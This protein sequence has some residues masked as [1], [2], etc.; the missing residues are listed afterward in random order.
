MK[1]SLFVWS[2]STRKIS[3]F[4]VGDFNVNLLK[5]DPN[6]VMDDFLNTFYSSYFFPLI[7][8]PTRVGDHSVSL[9]DNIF[10]NFLGK[11]MNSGILLSDLSDHFPIFQCSLLQA[12]GINYTKKPKYKR[13]MTKSNTSKFENMLANMSWD[14]IYETNNADLAYKKFMNIVNTSFNHCFPLGSSFKKN[15]QDLNKPWFTDDLLKLL[16]KKNKLYKKYALNPTP[17]THG[18]YKSCRN[19]YIHSIRSAKKNYFGEEFKRYSN[20]T[21]NTWKVINQILHRGEINSKLPLVFHDSENAVNIPF[22]IVQKF[23]DFF[24]KY[25]SGFS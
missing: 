4:I 24:C 5:C 25:W 18:A 23:Y 17:L 7:H 19:K 20:D 8:R 15:S 22:D 12:D 9:L 16:K 11:G 13:I 14:D 3:C 6:D 10:T 21:K 1:T 2:V